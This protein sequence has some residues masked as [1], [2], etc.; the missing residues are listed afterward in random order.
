MINKAKENNSSNP[1]YSW[2][3]M[4]KKIIAQTRNGKKQFELRKKLMGVAKLPIR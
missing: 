3:A 1:F 2:S 4:E